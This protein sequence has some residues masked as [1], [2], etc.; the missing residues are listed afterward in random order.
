[1]VCSTPV[2]SGTPV[3]GAGMPE[4]SRSRFGQEKGTWWVSYSGETAAILPRTLTPTSRYQPS[5]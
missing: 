4:G 1:M 3:F 5:L 2:Q